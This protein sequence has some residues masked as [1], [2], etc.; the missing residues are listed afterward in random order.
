MGNGS[1]RLCKISALWIVFTKDV[2]IADGQV[3]TLSD[4]ASG[5]AK[6]CF[7]VNSTVL[8]SSV[9]LDISDSTQCGG[10]RCPACFQLDTNSNSIDLLL[11]NCHKVGT[12]TDGKDDSTYIS[13]I[14]I[15]N[16]GSKKATVGDGTNTYVL[17][18]DDNMLAGV[19]PALG[20]YCFQGRMSCD[21]AASPIKAKAAQGPGGRHVLGLSLLVCGLV[22]LAFALLCCDCCKRW[23][24]KRKKD[25]NRG[26]SLTPRHPEEALSLRTDTSA[27]SGSDE[28][29]DD[30]DLYTGA[31][32]SSANWSSWSVFHD[33]QQ[34]PVQYT[35]VPSSAPMQSPF[36]Q[37][38]A[39]P[40]KQQQQKPFLQQQQQLQQQAIATAEKIPKPLTGPAKLQSLMPP[41]ISLS[42][43]PFQGPAQQLSSV[44]FGPDPQ[45][46]FVLSSGSGGANSML[47][48]PPGPLFRVQP[49]ERNASTR[50]DQQIAAFV[51]AAQAGQLQVE[52]STTPEP[53]SLEA[54]YLSGAL[55]AIDRTRPNL[56]PSDPNQLHTRFESYSGGS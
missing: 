26:L 12:V 37:S 42:P 53:I 41:G 7:T 24:R 54:E 38:C 43:P 27:E 25:R 29:T 13:R 9:T 15:A 1:Q 17:A 55:T 50:D 56:P 46:S 23:H 51:E 40:E 30:D 10:K 31:P 44:S 48:L 6:D 2:Q 19:V 33:K 3:F 20:C 49:Q 32:P 22:A 35:A 39:S 18:R 8:T 5:V 21:S 36:F 28:S 11:S 52:A 47:G 4:S 45:N 34:P 16:I 14:Q